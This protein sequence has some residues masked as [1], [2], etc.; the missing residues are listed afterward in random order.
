MIQVTKPSLPSL[1]RYMRELKPVWE[2]KILTNN[3]QEC[4]KLE[5]ILRD[6][7]DNPHTV[8]V[9]SGHSALEL[10]LQ[11]VKD[12]KECNKPGPIGAAQTKGKPAY[13]A[14]ESFPVDAESKW[15]V[16]T[17]PFTFISTTLAILRMGMRPIFCDI[18]PDTL[19]MDPDQMESKITPRTIAILPV[20]VYGNICKTSKIREIAEKYGLSVIYDAAHAFDERVQGTSIA[21]IGDYVCFSFHATKPFYTGEGGAV[22]CAD[23]EKAD[24]IR[25]LRN[26]G[27]DPADMGNGICGIGTNA[28]MSELHAALGICCLEHLE[29]DRERRRRIWQTYNRRLKCTAGLTL[30]HIE[31][32]VR[33]NYAYYPVLIDPQAF[34][35]DRDRVQQVL[36]ECRVETRRYFYPLTSELCGEPHIGLPNA[37]KASRQVLALPIYP[38]LP[39]K[40][41]E[42]ICDILLSLYRVRRA[43]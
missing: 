33:S 18:D 15:E 41:A 12:E 23:Q 28:K 20:H 14:I 40:E 24:R 21:G 10:A 2:T 29:A 5:E 39:R 6:I 31:K 4:R 30:P 26:F 16:I 38:S 7:L 42:R 22:C 34:G 1:Y 9:S 19:T 3:G 43:A 27:Y 11:A 35:T 17:T 8:L 25:R 36:A 13:S 32:G 37:F